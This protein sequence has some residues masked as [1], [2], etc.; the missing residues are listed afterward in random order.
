VCATDSSD[1]DVMVLTTAVVNNYAARRRRK[2][3]HWVHAYIAER[4]STY[5]TF[6]TSRDLSTYPN[7]FKEMYRMSK[8]SF[9][10][11]CLE[12]TVPL[13]QSNPIATIT[14]KKYSGII[15]LAQGR[16]SGSNRSNYGLPLRHKLKGSLYEHR[17]SIS[18]KIRA[19]HIVKT[20]SKHL[21]HFWIGKQLI[22]KLFDAVKC[23]I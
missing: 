3:E 10:E 4:V 13:R 1:E 19:M 16:V 7:K 20:Y 23:E 17:S 9:N 18:H 22:R 2:R 11:M 14:K 8:E 12:A 6:A 21:K 5:G 15:I